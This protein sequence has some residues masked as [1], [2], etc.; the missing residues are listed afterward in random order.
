MLQ[1]NPRLLRV[2]LL[3]VT[4]LSPSVV[5]AQTPQ[6]ATA[7]VEAVLDRLVDSWNTDDLTAHVAEYA[8]DATYTLPRGVVRGRDAIRRALSGFETPD[9]LRGVLAFDGVAVRF[10]GDGAAL[11]TGRFVLEFEEDARTSSGRFSL[12]LVRRG[13]VWVIVHDHSS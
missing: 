1:P 5:T 13:D 3:A 7:Q 10:L 12:V 9:G 6:D 4:T 2:V 8:E 11:A